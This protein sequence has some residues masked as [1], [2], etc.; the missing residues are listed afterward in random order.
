MVRRAWLF[1]RRWLEIDQL[2]DSQHIPPILARAL[3]ASPYVVYV[4][5]FTAA[6]ET[7]ISAEMPDV[8]IR[9]ALELPCVRE[10]VWELCACPATEALAMRAL[11][12]VPVEGRGRA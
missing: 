3:A 5:D 6:M 7:T 11:G 8:A 2:L 1:E 9:G 12:T 10:C 4:L